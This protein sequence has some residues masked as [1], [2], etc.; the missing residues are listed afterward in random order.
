MMDAGG[1]ASGEGSGWDEEGEL[2]ANA[3]GDVVGGGKVGEG[4]VGGEGVA[5]EDG[6]G[7]G[8]GGPADAC[9]R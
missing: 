5:V 2:D 7:V 6:G 4:G 3:V 1:D 9:A 8:G